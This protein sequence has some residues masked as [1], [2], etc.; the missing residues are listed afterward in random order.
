MACV[1]SSVLAII[2]YILFIL[3][4]IASDIFETAFLYTS[5]LSAVIDEIYNIIKFNV[6]SL[7][8]NIYVCT[9][10][11]IPHRF[12][13]KLSIEVAIFCASHSRSFNNPESSWPTCGIKSCLYKE[14]GVPLREPPGKGGV[15][16]NAE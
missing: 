6:N 5:T 9:E 3:E 10:C 1:T 7:S 8:I 13:V 11:K 2:V 12:S 4:S 16:E 15:S 14:L